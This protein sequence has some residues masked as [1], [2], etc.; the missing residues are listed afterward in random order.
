MTD[1]DGSTDGGDTQDDDTGPGGT[2]IQLTRPSPPTPSTGTDAVVAGPGP[3]SDG[4]ADSV[5]LVDQRMRQRRI[6]VQRDAGQRRLRRLAWILLPF[7]AL[8]A[9]AIA[10]H[11]PMVNVDRIL[12]AG[13]QHTSTATVIWASGIH[14]GDTLVTLD[15]QRAEQQIEQLSWVDRADVVREWPGTVRISVT[16]RAPVVALDRGERDAVLVDASG[17]ILDIGGPLPEGVVTLTGVDDQLGE[18]RDLPST[19]T[20]AL[21]LA[22]ALTQRL[23]GQVTSVTIDLDASL[24][25]GG[26]ARFGSLEDLRDKLVA[27]Q[28]ALSDIDLSCLDVLDL[29]VPSSLALRRT[30]C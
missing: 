19:A 10:I 17:R 28:A 3:D 15:E 4:L 13:N 23:P 7:A 6:R 24:S 8:A 26:I 29:R 1:D 20:P 21:D 25:V 2:V 5:V 30:E 16:D 9:G 22:V 18:G 11:L 12:V 14:R 27:L